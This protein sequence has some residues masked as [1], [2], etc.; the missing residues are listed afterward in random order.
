MYKL[1]KRWYL[2]DG[3]KPAEIGWETLGTFR[4]IRKA[5]RAMHAD[6]HEVVI[7]NEH[8][9]PFNG[10]DSDTQQSVSLSRDHHLYDMADSNG[11]HVEWEIVGLGKGFTHPIGYIL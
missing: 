9:L 10:T 6:V 7:A 8:R 11:S 5:R 3:E 4:K 1:L 2:S